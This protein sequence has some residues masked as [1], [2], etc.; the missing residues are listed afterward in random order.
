ML[1]SL[2][3]SAL[4]SKGLSAREAAKQ[5]GVA[6]TTVTRILKGK[7]VDLPTVELVSKWLGVNVS[8]ILGVNR[9]DSI[10]AKIALLVESSPALGGVLAEAVSQWEA[11]QLDEEDIREIIAYANYRIGAKRNAKDKA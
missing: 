9:S 4:K 1:T 2:L 3:A 11:G 6:H 7:Q 10:A 8:D 5:I